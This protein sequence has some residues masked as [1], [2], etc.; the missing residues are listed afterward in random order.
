[1]IRADKSELTHSRVLGHFLA[2]S[3]VRAVEVLLAIITVHSVS[4]TVVNKAPQ[5]TL[6]GVYQ[7]RRQ[8]LNT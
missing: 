3:P 4:E 2:G 6:T 1:M 7:P 5:P 8:T